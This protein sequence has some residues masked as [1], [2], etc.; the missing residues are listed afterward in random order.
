MNNKYY[1]PDGM[2]PEDAI[3]KVKTFI[4]ELQNVQ[5][6]YFKKLVSDLSLN[7][8]GE[9]WLFDYIYNV[10]DND[11]DGFDHYMEDFKKKYEDLVTKDILYNE[12]GSFPSTDFGEFSPMIN[13]TSYEPDLETAF[14]SAFTDN[15]VINNKLDTITVKNKDED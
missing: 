7:K 8:D 5:E 2:H 13:M 9:D 14:P 1:T 3:N 11:Y 6:E 10:S 15:D 12:N 4:N